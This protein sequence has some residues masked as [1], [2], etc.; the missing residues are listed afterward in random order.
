MSNITE[1]VR[2]SIGNEASFSGDWKRGE[3]L[4][5]GKWYPLQYAEDS[6]RWVQVAEDRIILH[7]RPGDRKF[8]RKVILFEAFRALARHYITRRTGELAR[9][10]QS[11]FNKITVKHVVS[12]WGSCSSKRNLNFNWHLIFLPPHLIDYIIIH[13]LMHLRE[14]NHSPAYWAWVARYYPDYKAAKQEIH[15]QQW[16]IG[17]LS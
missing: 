2:D 9:E 15:Q 12:K 17:I 11:T 3:I 4:Y 10:T 1:S 7:I 14:M 16:L 13:E 6:R 8:D 5:M